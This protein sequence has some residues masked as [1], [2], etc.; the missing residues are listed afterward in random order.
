MTRSTVSTGI[1]HIAGW[2]IFLSLPILFITGLPGNNQLS[3]IIASPAS[4]M[5]FLVYIIIF[6]SNTYFLIP[7]LYQQKK[8][9]LYILSITV[10]FISIFFLRPFDNMLD[11]LR[12]DSPPSNPLQHGPH[13]PGPKGGPNFDMVSIFLLIVIL[14]LSMAI[15]AR[16][17]LR[18]TQQQAALAE[19]EKA[20]A[21]LSFLKAQI[22]PHFLFNTLNN[23]Y[24]L[25]ITRNEHTA[26]SIM[27][28][29]NILRY[30]TD[31][32]GSDFVA[33]DH[34]IACI[35]DYIDLQK[36]RLSKETLVNFSITGEPVGRKIAP[37]ILMTFIENIFKYGISNHEPSVLD[38][39]IAID[40]ACIRFKTLNNIFKNHATPDRTGTGIANARQRLNFLYLKSHILRIENENDY[41][42]VDLTLST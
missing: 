20:R 40:S 12:L 13:G 23:I 11:I 1:A 30:L 35:T 28:L 9:L 24:S 34:E 39:H 7:I 8:Y 18:R 25:A 31:D 16:Q 4:W 14:A 42:T 27:K 32:A 29:S 17:R 38:I 26:E 6:Y 37:L 19:T 21:E 22:N 36:L 3:T 41:F 33:L 5:F 15:E 2:L 10:I